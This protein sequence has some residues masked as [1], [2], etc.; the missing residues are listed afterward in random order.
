[1]LFI[2]PEEIVNYINVKAVPVGSLKELP[3]LHYIIGEC[4]NV[5][6]QNLSEA[7]G[8]LEHA[9]INGC[10]QYGGVQYGNR[11]FPTSVS[12]LLLAMKKDDFVRELNDKLQSTER[13]ASE[14]KKEI[15]VLRP[16]LVF[17]WN[18]DKH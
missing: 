5:E 2:K 8:V 1:M 7:I 16:R 13:T 11:Y 10:A 17:C 4:C 6:L 15:R 9:N 12:Y 14:L 3:P 18:K